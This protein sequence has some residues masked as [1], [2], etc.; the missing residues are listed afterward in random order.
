M[1]GGL[2]VDERACLRKHA[3][4]VHLDIGTWDGGS[5]AEAAEVCDLVFTLDKSLK[6]YD[7]RKVHSHLWKKII[8]YEVD[9]H[10]WISPKMKFDSAFVDGDHTHAGCLQDL[11]LAANLKAD[12]ILVHDMDLEAVEKAVAEFGWKTIDKADKM[13]V[14]K[15]GAD[16]P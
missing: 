3:R 12:V 4:G 14:L 11:R 2:T 9:S 7:V 6:H 10:G 15:R 8:P 1:L 13:V 16:T 5:A